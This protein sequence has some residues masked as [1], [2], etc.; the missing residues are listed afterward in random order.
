MLTEADRLF[1]SVG[2]REHEGFRLLSQWYLGLDPM[3]K[4]YAYHQAR[5]PNVAWVGSIASGKSV[6]ITASVAADCLTLP[7]FRAL[8]TSITSAQAEIPFEIF[9]SLYSDDMYHRRLEHLIEDVVKRPYPM[10]KFKNGSSWLFRTAGYQAQHIRGFEFDRI[11]FDEAGYE[12]DEETMRALRGRLRGERRPGVPRMAR[13][14]AATSPTSCPWLR[15]WFD[16]GDPSGLEPMLG[17][18]ASIR[19]TIYDNTHITDEQVRLMKAGYSDEMIRVELLGQFPEYGNTMFPEGHIIACESRLL[20]DEMEMALRPEMG[21]STPGYQEDVHPRHGIT[22]YETPYDPNELYILAG[23]PGSGDIPYRNAGC[24]VV[25]TA[26]A[27]PHRL[28]YFNW[29]SGNGSYMPFLNAY[30]YAIDKYRPNLRGIDA[31]GPQKALNELAFERLGIETVGLNFG[32]DKHAMVNALSLALTNHDLVY[33][34]IKGLHLQMSRYVREDDKMPND[35]VM[36]LA[37]IAYLL[38]HAE[39]NQPSDSSG[40]RT[41]RRD[42]KQRAIRKGA[43]TT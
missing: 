26:S 41:L 19:S 8:S 2:R 37:M 11:V 22:L 15:Q 16:R 20:N 7:G 25:Y 4:Q 36:T 12:Y 1:L 42:R 6:G 40:K 30:K 14:D 39:N 31:T 29:V 33:P 17:D 23:D 43:R 24:V 21:G 13:L 10:I 28:V 27:R 32:R 34:F 18:Y 5:Q 38:R 9:T 35:I 3:P